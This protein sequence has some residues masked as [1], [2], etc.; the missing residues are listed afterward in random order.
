MVGVVPVSLYK[1]WWGGGGG[2]QWGD[3]GVMAR[4]REV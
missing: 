2:V 3:G 1:V 4:L